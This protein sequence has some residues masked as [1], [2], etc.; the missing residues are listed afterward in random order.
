M[1]NAL[2]KGVPI[3]KPAFFAD[4][5]TCQ[6]TKQILPDP[7]Q[8]IPTLC[9][10]TINV[11]EVTLAVK[12]ERQQVYLDMPTTIGRITNYSL[13]NVFVAAGLDK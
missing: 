1:A 9:E 10:K 5:E 12:K 13:I 2:S 3:V 11:N 6:T 4:F 8:F 7:K